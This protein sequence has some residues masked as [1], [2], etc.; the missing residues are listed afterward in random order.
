MGRENGP[1]ADFTQLKKMGKQPHL[2][3]L[4]ICKKCTRKEK[5]NN[6]ERKL[7]KN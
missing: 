1:I 4:A 6:N 3:K 5:R 7:K 2:H